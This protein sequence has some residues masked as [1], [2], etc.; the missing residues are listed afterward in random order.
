MT[1]Q[2][3]DDCSSR[4]AAYDLRQLRAKRFT[5]EAD[6][7]WRYRV[8]SGAAPMNRSTCRAEQ[9]IGPVLPAFV[10][11]SRAPSRL[12]RDLGSLLPHGQH[13]VDR[14]A[15]SAHSAPRAVSLWSDS[16]HWTLGSRVLAPDSQGLQFFTAK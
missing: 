14:D 7:S 9:I 11:L 4:Q 10:A 2:T 6:E 16:T 13:F 5:V 15:A 3:E 12:F 1:D 8:Q